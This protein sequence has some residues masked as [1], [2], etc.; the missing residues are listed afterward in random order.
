M[1]KIFTLMAAMFLCSFALYAQ[2]EEEPIE[3]ENG[4]FD[5]QGSPYWA[6][7]FRDSSVGAQQYQ[8][9]AEIVVDPTDPTNHCARVV[10]RSEEQAREAENMTSDNG[11]DM[12]GWDSQFFVCSETAIPEGYEIKLVMRVRADFEGDT[13]PSCGTQ[14]HNDP[15]NY[16]HYACVGNLEFTHE[17]KTVEMTGTVSADMIQAAK[18]KEFHTITFNLADFKGGYTA[19]FDDIKF[20]VREPQETQPSELTGWFNLLRNGNETDDIYPGTN[21]HT[22]TGRDADVGQD[23]PARVVIDELDGLPAYTV[24]CAW[25]NIVKEEEVVDEETGEIMLETIK[26]YEYTNPNGE[27]VVLNEDKVT[28]WQAQFFLTVPHTFK[29]G[30]QYKL[31]MWARADTDCTVQT[32][33]HKNPGAYQH[34]A[35][36]GDLNLTPVW[37]EFWIGESEINPD[38]VQ[39]IIKEQDGCYTIAFNCNV[40]KD[41]PNNIYFRFDYFSFNDADVP[42]NERSLGREDITLDVTEKGGEVKTNNID[43]SN[44]ISTLGISPEEFAALVE[45]GNIT[46]QR[47]PVKLDEDDE[48]AAGEGWE[49]VV[50]KGNFEEAEEEEPSEDPQNMEVQ[51]EPELS[52]IS[53]FPMNNLGLYDDEGQFELEGS[54]AE[55]TIVPVVITNEGESFENQYTTSKFYFVYNGWNY[56]FNATIQGEKTIPDAIENVAT[57][58]QKAGVIYDLSGRRIVKPTKGLYIMDGKKVLVK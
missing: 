42:V 33:A 27:Y 53:G 37:Q 32:Q 29:T 47:V 55:G 50:K 58:N 41:A 9:P 3:P 36:I 54:D 11:T 46:I 44:C 4:W 52:L 26:Q 24:R 8:G 57:T 1:K 34:Y 22:F 6:H 7:D 56:C 2:D 23:L 16:N 43:F 18:G 28:D 51:Y 48:A 13:N 31:H 45:D 38:A 5:L 19:Y 30:E 40:F 12:V 39:T 14:A 20:Y 15:G 21:Y 35:M 10:V 25:F 49:N 17:W